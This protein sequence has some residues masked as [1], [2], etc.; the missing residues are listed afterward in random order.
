MSKSKKRRRKR[1]VREDLSILSSKFRLARTGKKRGVAVFEYEK[2]RSW[3]AASEQVEVRLP[4]I[5]CW[6]DRKKNKAA[7]AHMLVDQNQLDQRKFLDAIISNGSLD[8]RDGYLTGE[9][10]GSVGYLRIGSAAG[11]DGVY[12]G[13]DEEYQRYFIYD[14]KAIAIENIL[15]RINHQVQVGGIDLV[16]LTL[17]SDSVLIESGFE[18]VPDWMSTGPDMW[19]GNPDHIVKAGNS[20]SYTALRDN[21]MGFLK[22]MQASLNA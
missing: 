12:Q 8:S 13:T 15:K 5:S 16:D 4:L 7:K 1:H 14:S 20:Y 6:I 21:C 22:L 9:R 18:K 3:G 10:A 2:F 19:M 17:V 11:S